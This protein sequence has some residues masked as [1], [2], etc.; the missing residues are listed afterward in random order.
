V[1]QHPDERLA[2]GG[3]ENQAFDGADQLD[4]GQFKGKKLDFSHSGPAWNVRVWRG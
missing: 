4:R 2:L 1:G 3:G